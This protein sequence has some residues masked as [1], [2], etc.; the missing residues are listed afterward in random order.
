MVIK[1]WRLHYAVDFDIDER[2]RQIGALSDFFIKS[3][4]GRSL[5]LHYSCQIV[6]KI[7]GCTD[8]PDGTLVTT[9]PVSEIVRIH[10]GDGN[11][12]EYLIRTRERNYY[13]REKFVNQQFLDEAWTYGTPGL[14]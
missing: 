3:K 14:Y 13:T 4:P 10:C 6:G 8:I 11:D 1:N 5:N 9:A 12:C 7:Y 2:H